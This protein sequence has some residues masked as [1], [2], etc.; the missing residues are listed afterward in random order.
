MKWRKEAAEYI[1]QLQRLYEQRP[2]SLKTVYHALRKDPITGSYY[3]KGKEDRYTCALTDV[4][5]PTTGFSRRQSG[6]IQPL[7]AA[8][9]SYVNVS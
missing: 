4:T 5:D 3:L 9:S 7:T 2:R 6:A 1:Y 8:E